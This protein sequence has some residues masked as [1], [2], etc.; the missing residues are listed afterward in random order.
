MA[1]KSDLPRNVEVTQLPGT[2]L[3]SSVTGDGQSDLLQAISTALVPNVPSL[4]QLIPVTDEQ[5]EELQRFR[6]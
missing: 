5:V 6:A 2:L 1:H 4:G 3:V